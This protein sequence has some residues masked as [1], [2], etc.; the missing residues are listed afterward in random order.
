MAILFIRRPK[1]L[2]I[3]RTFFGNHPQSQNVAWCSFFLVQ[4]FCHGRCSVFIELETLV[5]TEI[6]IIL[7][8]SGGVS[9]ARLVRRP[10][11]IVQR[12]SMRRGQFE[13]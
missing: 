11:L 8:H 2:N 6:H 13:L 12:T 9:L 4:E 7:V 5:F 1:Q 10:F 3:R